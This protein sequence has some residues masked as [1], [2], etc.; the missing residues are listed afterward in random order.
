MRGINNGD[1]VVQRIKIYA[2][3]NVRQRGR[4]MRRVRCSVLHIT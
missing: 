4:G 2:Q 1:D 3:I